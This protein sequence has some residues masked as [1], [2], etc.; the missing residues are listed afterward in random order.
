MTHKTRSL[1]EIE[2]SLLAE[3]PWLVRYFP[4]GLLY[5]PSMLLLLGGA[6]Y[7]LMLIFDIAVGVVAEAQSKLWIS[8]ASCALG[9]P[10]SYSWWKRDQIRDEA[11]K[12]FQQEQRSAGKHSRIAN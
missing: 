3:Q 10:G 12:I 7:F 2:A 6:G 4:P 5:V 1:E 9:L 11:E 8:I